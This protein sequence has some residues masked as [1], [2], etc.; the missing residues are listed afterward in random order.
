[1]TLSQIQEAFQQADANGDGEISRDEF[2]DWVV[3]DIEPTAAESIAD[4]AFGAVSFVNSIIFNSGGG[5][6][7]EEDAAP[8]PAPA[9]APTPPP[10]VV[11]PQSA[12]DA[13]KYLS[14]DKLKAYQ[15]VLALP[16]LAKAGLEELLEAQAAFDKATVVFAKEEEAFKSDSQM[17]V[18][19]NEQLA[20]AK[21][22]RRTGEA[23]Q[24]D[25]RLKALR[26]PQPPAPLPHGGLRPTSS[27]ISTVTTA[28]AMGSAAETELSNAVLYD[29]IDSLLD[30]G[31]YDG[32]DWVEKCCKEEVR[33]C[34]SDASF[35]Q[36][37]QLRM[38]S[39]AVTMEVDADS[40]KTLEAD[41]GAEKLSK[42]THIKCTGL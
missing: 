35:S 5:G 34:L 40:L 1:M 2:V 32:A 3:S 11:T 29:V 18:T 21:K 7:E 24:L 12:D 38:A 30:K 36:L 13:S 37:K 20:L 41:T 15:G 6:D 23:R 4:T 27:S 25:G 14:S 33:R 42:V 31:D 26:P 28:L 22:E 10:P 16:S 17:S 19:L 8:P 39:E 9:P